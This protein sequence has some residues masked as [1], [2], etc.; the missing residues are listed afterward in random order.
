MGFSFNAFEEGKSEDLLGFNQR[1]IMLEILLN[2]TQ[3]SLTIKVAAN[4]YPYFQVIFFMLY[5]SSSNYFR[6]QSVLVSLT[7]AIL[8]LLVYRLLKTLSLDNKLLPN[9][10]K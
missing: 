7:V 10:V 8:I 6:F 5:F 4:A 1:Q 2:I 9:S 3:S